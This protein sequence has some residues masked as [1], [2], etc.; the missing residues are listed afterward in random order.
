MTPKIFCQELLICT[1]SAYLN[2]F[3][4]VE[5]GAHHRP[6]SQK[7]IL[8]NACRQGMMEVA[9]PE[10]LTDLSLININEGNRFLDLRF[11]SYGQ[12]VEGDFSI[13]PYHFLLTERKN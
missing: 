5:D 13:N 4:A 9:L 2:R 7:E 12:H 8:A 1:E 10:V 11:S 6:E 3:I